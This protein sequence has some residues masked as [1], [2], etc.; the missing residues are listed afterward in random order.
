MMSLWL[1]VRFSNA[2]CFSSLLACKW[3]FSLV[4]V[5]LFTDSLLVAAT[6]LGK[7]RFDTIINTRLS[8]SYRSILLC[9]QLMCYDCAES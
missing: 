7:W 2:V 3:D 5:Q 1:T 4:S 8:F 9:L 6:R